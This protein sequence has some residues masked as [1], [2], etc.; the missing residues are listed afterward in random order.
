MIWN[1]RLPVDGWFNIE[2]T[3]GA[4]E[5]V[6]GSTFNIGSAGNEINGTIENTGGYYSFKTKIV[7]RI[8]LQA[9]SSGNFEIQAVQLKSGSLMNLKQLRLIP[10]PKQALIN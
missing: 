4:P 6:S 8:H 1:Y 7:G 10:V 9:N 5:E 2:I 3:Y